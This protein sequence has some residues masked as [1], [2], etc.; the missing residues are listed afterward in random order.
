MDALPDASDRR[1]AALLGCPMH[2]SWIPGNGNGDRP[3]IAEV[4]GQGVFS[5][6]YIL[7]IWNLYFICQNIHAMPPIIVDDAD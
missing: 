2:Q 3:P 4:N 1:M 7:N 5:Y 6:R